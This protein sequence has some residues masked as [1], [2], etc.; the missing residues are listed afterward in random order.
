MEQWY[1]HTE[2]YGLSKQ[3][4]TI[5]TDLRAKDNTVLRKTIAHEG[6]EVPGG[7]RKLHKRSAIT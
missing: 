6:Q 7:C 1:P 3:R 5:K 4:T 2:F